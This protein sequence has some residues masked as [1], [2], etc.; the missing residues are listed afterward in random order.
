MDGRMFPERNEDG[1]D[2]SGMSIREYLTIEMMKA[3][4]TRDKA[5]TPENAATKAL[6]YS[7]ALLKESKQFNWK[8]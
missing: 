6:E 7:K 1:W 5:I 4:V 8:D 2:E 3:V